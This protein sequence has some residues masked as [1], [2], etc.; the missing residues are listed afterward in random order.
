MFMNRWYAY[1]ALGISALMLSA[2]N[3]VKLE[4]TW[5]EP[6]PG[7]ESM[8]QGF[9]L[10][11]GGAASS[12]NMATLQYESWKRDGDALMLSGHS[13]G[14]G[15][16][17]AFTDTMSIVSL[18]QDSL[19]LKRG[20]M[21]VKYARSTSEAVATQTDVAKSF[22]VK[23]ILTLAHEVRSFVA[24]GDTTEYWVVD[25]TGK[26]AQ[27]YDEL[28]GGVKNGTPVYVEMTVTD[29]GKSDEGFAEGYYS[30]Y[31]VEEIADMRM[32]E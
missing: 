23:G 26:L 13:I 24:E 32:P 1:V 6:V 28:T 7:N 21:L 20:T 11:Q 12:V 30:V 19:V 22:P 17:L 18:T 15:Q 10:E 5:I 2:C 29:M 31:R 25:R 16:T 9:T 27:Q 3:D 8:V 4:G 14:N